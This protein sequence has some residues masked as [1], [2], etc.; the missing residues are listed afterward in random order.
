MR[1][2]WERFLEAFGSPNYIDNQFQW[3]WMPDEGLFL[4]QGIHS[5]PAY[6]LDNVNILLSFGSGLLESLL[7]PCTSSERLRPFQK[8]KAG[9]E[10]K[11]GPDR[12]S[13]FGHWHQSG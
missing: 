12:T 5:I 8:G 9:T 2:L 6:D 1:S 4:T 10:G 11:V 13:T 3:E 7:V